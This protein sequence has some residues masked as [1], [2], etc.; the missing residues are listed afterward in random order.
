MDINRG[1]SKRKLHVISI[2]E[3]YLSTVGY[4]LV[5][6]LGDK[7]D[8]SPITL[9]E[10]TMDIISEQDIVILSKEILKGITRPF[11]PESCLI[12]VAEREINIASTKELMSLPKGQQ[13][14]IINDTFE[15]AEETAVS[16]ENIYFE[17]DYVPYDPLHPIPSNIDF[18]I[19]PGEIELVPKQFGN[20]I[21]IGPRT[22][23]F[24][25]VVE[26]VK[27][28]DCKMDQSILMNRL[29]KSQLS[30][31]EKEQD[32]YVKS[33]RSSPARYAI[34]NSRTDSEMPLTEEAIRIMIGK[35]EAHGFLEE[36]IAILNIYKEAKS[37]FESFGRTK[38]KLKLREND[39]HLSDQQLR[40][41]LEVMQEMGLVIARSGRGGTKLSDKG[42]VFL[43][44][45]QEHQAIS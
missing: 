19:T 11:I 38:V 2:Q 24:N 35:I 33:T 36:S 29:F 26:I 42:E 37:K 12:I 25:T 9:Q 39:V 16:L 45:F 31:A 40:L 28:L 23:A 8:V 6:I 32:H 41:R 4:Q 34:E 44:Y 17:H 18:I 27:Y 1:N 15:H 22:L 21:D 30:L 10:L 13:I 3:V 7:I 43:K 20:V 5:D 14:L